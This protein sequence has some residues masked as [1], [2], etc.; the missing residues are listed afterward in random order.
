MILILVALAL[1]FG[2][3]LGRKWHLGE[4]E[5]EQEI[6]AETRARGGVRLRSITIRR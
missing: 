2:F 5:A 3:E 4:V 1:W 6:F